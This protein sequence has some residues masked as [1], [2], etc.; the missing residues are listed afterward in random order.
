MF[1]DVR[2]NTF[3]EIRHQ[4]IHNSHADARTTQSECV[5]SVEHNGTNILVR[6]SFTQ[7]GGMASYKVVLKLFKLLIF[8]TILRHWPKTR[9]N[10]VN[11]FIL[12]EL[13]QKLETLFN[14]GSLLR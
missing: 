1:W 5:Q 9:I 8:N 3:V 10:A 12:G 11:D 6:Q 14:N 2:V 13:S 4:L 7:T